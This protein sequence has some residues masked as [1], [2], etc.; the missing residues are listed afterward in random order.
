MLMLVMISTP[1][2]AE[3]VPDGI[4]SLHGTTW[5]ATALCTTEVVERHI[6]FYEGKVFYS[7]DSVNWYLCH[8]IYPSFYVDLLA[9]KFFYI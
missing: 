9:I 6:G 1:C 4:F 8:D 7:R 5:L 3:V 2:L